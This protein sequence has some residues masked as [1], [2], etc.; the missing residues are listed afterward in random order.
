MV[1]QLQSRED[2]QETVE[3]VS[4]NLVA[5]LLDPLWGSLD[6]VDVDQT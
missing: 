4:P 2:D 3:E 5:E 1:L 6:F